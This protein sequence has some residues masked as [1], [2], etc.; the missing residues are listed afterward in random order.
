MKAKIANSLFLKYQTSL[1]LK[2][3]V[4]KKEKYNQRSDNTL[5]KRKVMNQRVIERNEPKSNLE[6]KGQGNV[7]EIRKIETIQVAT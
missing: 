2:S 6:R 1:K 5:L 7:R 4:P 3:N